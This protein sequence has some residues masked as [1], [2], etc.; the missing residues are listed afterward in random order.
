M[1]NLDGPCRPRRNLCAICGRPLRRRRNAS[2]DRCVPCWRLAQRGPRLRELL[3]NFERI[4]KLG[5]SLLLCAIKLRV[6]ES[7][8]WNWRRGKTDPS[9]ENVLQLRQFCAEHRYLITNAL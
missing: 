9:A 5:P 2:H 7:T 3:R 1:T 4:I 8:I 6:S